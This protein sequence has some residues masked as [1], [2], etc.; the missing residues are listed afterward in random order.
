MSNEPG[1]DLP[2][3]R[4]S[5]TRHL[6]YFRLLGSAALLAALVPSFTATGRA[7]LAE[8]DFV[9]RWNKIAEDTLLPAPPAA[10]KTFQNEGLIYMAYVSAAMYDAVTVIQGG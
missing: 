5:M 10:A 8:N 7:A 9:L 1:H 4:R 6:S 2:K 3:E